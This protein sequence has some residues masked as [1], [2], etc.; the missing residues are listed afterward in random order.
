MQHTRRRRKYTED[1]LAGTEC[2]CGVLGMGHMCC[3][4]NGRRDECVT[5]KWDGVLDTQ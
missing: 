2:S 5:Q 1:A 3:S 4:L